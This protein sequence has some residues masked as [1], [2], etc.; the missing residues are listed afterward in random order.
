MYFVAFVTDY[1]GTIAADGSVDQ[2]TLEALRRLRESRR[3]LVLATGRELADLK[4]VFSEL[5]LFDVVA[6]ENGA[7]LYLPA[8]EEERLLAPLPD[9]AFV[10]RLRHQGVEPLSIGRS[11]VATW[12]PN[13]GKVLEI[14]SEMGLDL[15]LTFNK[16]AVM[17]LPP[18][19]N[20]GSGVAAALEHL[21]ISPRNAIGIGDAEN[22]EAFLRICGRSV[23]VANALPPVKENADYVTKAARGQGVT[24]FIDLLLASEADVFPCEP[25]P[26][27]Q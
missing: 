2:T 20:K 26:Q 11:I 18:G 4:V 7:V 24:E 17:V 15:Q 21:A 16:G 6:A 14:I 13:E 25:N 5:N 3:K 10:D 1:D 8:T 12:E 23:A 19:V 22:D 9:Q 27:M